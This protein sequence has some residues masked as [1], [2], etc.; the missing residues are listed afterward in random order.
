MMTPMMPVSQAAI[1]LGLGG[2][3]GQLDDELKKRKKDQGTATDPRPSSYGD[4]LSSMSLAA[5]ELF[6]TRAR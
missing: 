5:T 6:G 3:S 1:D 2:L 4:T